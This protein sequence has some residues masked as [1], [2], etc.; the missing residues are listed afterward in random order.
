MQM[1]ELA[2]KQWNDVKKNDRLI[3][4]ETWPSTSSS[5]MRGEWHLRT[6]ISLSK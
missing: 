1:R 3:G 6:R 2:G 5:I 4:A